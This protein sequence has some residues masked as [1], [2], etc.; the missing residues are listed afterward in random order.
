MPKYSGFLPFSSS[1]QG[2]PCAIQCLPILFFLRVF[3]YTAD[4]PIVVQIRKREMMHS[5]RI[6]QDFQPVFCLSA[7][8]QMVCASLAV[9]V[10]LLFPSRIVCAQSAR[11]TEIDDLPLL[12][13][14]QERTSAAVLDFADWMDDFFSDERAIS[15]ENRTRIKLEMS[16]GYSRN[17]DFEVKPRL[18][19]RIDLPHLNRKL[20]LLLFASDDREFLVEQKPLPSLPRQQGGGERQAAAALQYFFKEE[21]IYNISSTFGGSYDYL[22]AGFRFRYSR[23]IGSW[24]GRCINRLR[25]FTDD[26]LVDN[27]SYDLERQL[28]EKWLFRTTAAA[29]WLEDRDG[30]AHSLVFRLFQIINGEKALLY[31]VGSYLDT[32]ESYAMTDLQ[33]HLRYRQRFLRDW[34]ILEI[35]PQIT[36]P[37][38][39]DRQPNPGFIMKLEAEF[40]NLAGLDIFSG[41]FDF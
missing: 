31:E 41:I 4:I 22:Y 13:S 35:A 21:D 25:Y 1:G 10:F 17:D 40:G 23:D 14:A 2:R 7:W 9:A 3:L 34:L 6:R 5:M 11:T 29:E 16:L 12:D 26:G 8:R 39:Y 30:L 36:F 19:G 18:S 28:A 32:E 24:R 33:V 37:Q 15:E 38:E 20:N 27:L